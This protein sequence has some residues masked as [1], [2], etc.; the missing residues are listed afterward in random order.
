[1]AP[2]LISP[3]RGEPLLLYIT[4]TTQVVSAML[5]IERDEAKH[6][7]KIQRLV[8]F[9]SEVLSDTKI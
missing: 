5:V 8:Y 4:I 6:S 1:M 2:T 9:I 3:E 7:H